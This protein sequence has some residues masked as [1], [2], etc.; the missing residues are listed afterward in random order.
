MTSKKRVL[1]DEIRQA[2]HSLGRD[3]NE[4]KYAVVL[5]YTSYN[6][7]EMYLRRLNQEIR[8]KTGATSKSFKMAPKPSPEGMM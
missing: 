7:L 1:K 2:L 5:R 4:P 3:Y 6:G 8:L